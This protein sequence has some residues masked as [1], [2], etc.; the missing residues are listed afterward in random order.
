MDY[1]SQCNFIGHI[2]KLRVSLLKS[3]FKEGYR[4]FN[5]I[6]MF[7]HM[8]ISIFVLTFGTRLIK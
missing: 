7:K 3:T 4:I 2:T 1:F 5:K 6:N 8:D